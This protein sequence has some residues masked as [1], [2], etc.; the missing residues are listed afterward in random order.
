MSAAGT[1]PPPPVP[2]VEGPQAAGD[3]SARSNEARTKVLM[4]KNYRSQRATVNQRTMI[5]CEFLE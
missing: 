2:A 3:N 1:P 5:E 4:R